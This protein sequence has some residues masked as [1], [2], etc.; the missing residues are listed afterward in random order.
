MAAKHTIIITESGEPIFTDTSFKNAC[1][2]IGIP[3][4]TLKVRDFPIEY[5]RFLIYKVPHKIKVLPSVEAS[6]QSIVNKLKLAKNT[7]DQAIT[8]TKDLK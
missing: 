7:I 4:N 3:Y 8:A 5:E 6:K 2:V 1:E